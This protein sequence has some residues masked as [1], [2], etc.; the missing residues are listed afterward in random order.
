MNKKEDRF[1]VV[2]SEG[3]GLTSANRQV[4]IDKETGVNY[5]FFQDGY[6]GG[7]TV[8]VDAMGKPLVTPY[9]FG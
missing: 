3:N 1:V 2:K 6:A 5:L 9:T 7:L 8:L 4:I